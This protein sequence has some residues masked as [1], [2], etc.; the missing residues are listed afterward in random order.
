MLGVLSTALMLYGMSIVFGLTG[1]VGFAE[2]AACDDDGQVRVGVVDALDELRA[3]GAGH[4]HVGEH[5]DGALVVQVVHG[6]VGAMA[7]PPTDVA[8]L[9][10]EHD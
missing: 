8:V 7:Q 5:G 3:V 2:I 10:I 4:A 9:V 1:S 6:V